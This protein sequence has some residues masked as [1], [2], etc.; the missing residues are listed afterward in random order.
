MMARVYLVFG[1]L[2][3]SAYAYAE[4]RGWDFAT[5][6]KVVVP[7]DVRQSPGGYRTFH[8]WHSGYH[9]GK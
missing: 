6:Q 5:E 7:G 4:A 1:L 2:L 8:F 3:V 9:G